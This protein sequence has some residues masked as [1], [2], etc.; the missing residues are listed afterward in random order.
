[1]RIAKSESRETTFDRD[2]VGLPALE[3]VLE[4]LS[5]QLCD[6]LAR[7]SRQGRTIGIKLRYDDFSTVTRARTVERATCELEAVLR[8][9]TELLRELA[10]SRP[11]RLLGVRVAGLDHEPAGTPEPSPDQLALAF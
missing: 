5:E 2:L 1:V 10:P 6:A 3:P 4:R 11:V 7:E 9:A 8:I